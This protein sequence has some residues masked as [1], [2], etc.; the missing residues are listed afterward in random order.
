MVP[1]ILLALALRV[2][3]LQFQPLWW[4]EGYSVW[5]ATHPLGQMAA[6][7]AEDIHPP[8]YY[9]LLHGWTGLLGAGPVA[10]RLFS[11]IVGLLAVPAIY[12][13][14]RRLYGRRVGLLAAFL[15]AI[16]PLHIY[17]SQEV[18]MYGLVALLSCA[19]LWA[20]WRV[21]ATRATRRANPLLLYVLLATAALYTQY[22]AVFVPL[23]LS[24]YAAW[25]WRS[26]LRALGRWLGAQ[27]GVALLYLPWVLYASPKLIPYVSQKVVQDAD[28]P[29]GPATYLGR[30]LAAYLAGHLEGPLAPYWPAALLLLIPLAAGWWLA[31]TRGHR[32]ER[33]RGAHNGNERAP[34]AQGGEATSPVPREERARPGRMGEVTSPIPIGAAASATSMLAITTG[35]IFLLGFLVSLRY[36]F[37]PDRGERLLLLGLPSF[38]L[39]AAAALDALWF[40]RRIAAVAGLGL[41]GAVAGASLGAFYT[42]PRY[43]G[44]DYRALIARSVEQG[45]PDDTVLCI[46]PWQVGYWRSYGSPD[47]P[48]A[49]LAP[50]PDW[51][52]VLSASIDSALSEGHLWFPA[53]LSLGAGTERRVE[54]YLAG[55]ARPFANQWY[56]P[57]TRLSAWDAGSTWGGPALQALAAP[58]VRFALPDGGQVT[59]E[60]LD[61]QAE[62]VPAA[63]AVTPLTLKWAAGATPPDLAVSVRLVDSLGQMWAQNDYEPLG[64]TPSSTSADGASADGAAWQAEDR[65]G[66]L[67]PAGTP[68]GRYTIQVIVRPAAASPGQDEPPLEASDAGGKHLG[69]S[70]SL[71]AL[72]VAPADRA[73]GPER[74]PIATR[75]PAG[76][77]DGL[78]FLGYSM[79]EGPLVPGE[80]RR[81]SLFWQATV[82]PS[83]DYTAF[84]QLIDKSGRLK[85]LWEAAPGAGYPTGQWQPGTLIRTQAYFRPGADLPDGRYTV[86]AGLFR[87]GDGSRL[88]T[89][90]GADHLTLAGVAVRGRPHDMNAPSPSHPAEAELG[91]LA[92]L[93]GF[94]LPDNEPLPAGATFP[95]TLYWQALSTPE[96]TYTV[97]V[98]LVDADGAPVGFGDG[99]PGGGRY[100]T[101]GWLP[102]EYLAD[103]HTITI[104]PATAPGS[105][106]VAVGLYDPA[107]GQRLTTPEGADQI[108]LE[109]Q[110]VVETAQP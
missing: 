93:A 66:L 36:P 9:A 47:G 18:R 104:A 25:R 100:P 22:Y 54:A 77:G 23:G 81:V 92:R 1:L 34:A 63:N 97:F 94:D 75:Q 106:R 53:H 17:Y 101:T 26:D 107:T 83:A 102:G 61:G 91:G 14:G 10:L 42:V 46:Y 70:A 19:T 95:L 41:V 38:L 84:V 45:A 76:L 87:P 68:P 20:A 6:L 51:G 85:A 64:G 50:S 37:F 108:L 80:L 67:V 5:F 99:E 29:L 35:G 16:N 72:E 44:D 88:A 65:L 27:I 15:L 55:K 98:H 13:T 57:G 11:V 71:L 78:R 4:D 8:L 89:Q 62:A 7:T 74:L 39:L 30:H 59:L 86:I 12:V 32:G 56:G 73:L 69:T 60:G 90:R 58:E 105:Y 82:T 33:G 21:F 49:I 96:R 3:C 48:V 110:V 24:L 103:T 79:D 109:P 52:P 2:V 28:R 31:G 43:A 40:S